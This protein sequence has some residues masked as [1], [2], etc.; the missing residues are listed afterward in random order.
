MVALRTQ[1]ILALESGVG[2]VAD[3]LGGSWYVEELTDEVERRACAVMDEIAGLGGMVAA[4]KAGWLRRLM[5]ERQW[6]LQSSIESGERPIVGVNCHRIPPEQDTLLS[7]RGEHPEPSREQVRIVTEF[8]RRRD[9]AGVRKA[10]DALHARVEVAS[11]NLIVP[12][13]SAVM[14]G[15][16]VGEVLGTIRLAYGLP[17]DP[18]NSVS[19]GDTV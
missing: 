15:A 13:K 17:Y 3:P 1:Q 12:I 16:T 11:E 7:F 14:A 2:N 19:A 10:L 4:A 8:R 6:A 9:A 5:D 18:V